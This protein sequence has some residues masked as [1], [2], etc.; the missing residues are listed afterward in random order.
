MYN[1]TKGAEDDELLG[2]LNVTILNSKLKLVPR[3]KYK[4][5]KGAIESSSKDRICRL[6][7]EL[8][9]RLTRPLRIP[10]LEQLDACIKSTIKYK[11]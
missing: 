1:T 9:H 4:K 10:A 2:N 6:I 11:Y 7:S 5:K 8:S 3:P